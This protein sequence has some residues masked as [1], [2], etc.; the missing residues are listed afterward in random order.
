MLRREFGLSTA[1]AGY[2]LDLQAKAGDLGGKM[3]E[4]LGRGLS[5]VVFDNPTGRFLIRLS[6]TGDA[7]Q[8]QSVLDSLGLDGSEVVIERDGMDYIEHQ[9]LA[10]SVAQRVLSVTRTGRASVVAVPGG[11][12]ITLAAGASAGEQQ[13]IADAAQDPR[14]SVKRVGQADLRPRPVACVRYGTDGYCDAARG[15]SRWSDLHHACTLGWWAGPSAPPYPNFLT[16]GHC[17]T[18]GG[19]AVR[20]CNASRSSCP[21]MA[22]EFGQRWGAGGDNGLIQITNSSWRREAGFTDW[23]NGSRQPLTY[24]PGYWDYNQEAGKVACHGGS[25]TGF[26]CGTVQG[27]VPAY[28]TG[29][30]TG[31]NGPV[32]LDS[33]VRVNGICMQGGDSGGPV[34]TGDLR[35]GYGIVSGSGGCNVFGDFEGLKRMND[36]YGLLPYGG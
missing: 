18:P 24:L 20:T 2:N 17:I 23:R 6:P 15:G 30:P 34:F 35:G 4:G 27:V 12:Q 29:D 26:S 16:A 25:T 8:A 19:A 5:Q 32:T 33:M 7:A 10:D 31:P 1:R 36:T 11:V 21:Y 22:G 9:Q 14:V 13:T 3:L 28:D